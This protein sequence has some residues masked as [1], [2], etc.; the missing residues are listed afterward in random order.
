MTTKASTSAGYVVGVGADVSAPASAAPRSFPRSGGGHGD[1]DDDEEEDGGELSASERAALDSATGSSACVEGLRTVGAIVK[2][3]IGSGVLF[4][5]KAF[6]DGGWLASVVIMA[7][8]ALVTQ[9]TIVRLV[10]CRTEMLSRGARGVSFA[11]IGA[12]VGGPYAQAAVDVSLVLSQAGFCC[13]Y[14]AFIARNALQLI[15]AGACWAPG[16]HLWVLVLLQAPVLVPL[17][18]V[19]KLRSFALTNSLANAFICCGLLG[20]LTYCIVQWLR[21]SGGSLLYA[22]PAFNGPDFPV[23]LGTAVY[24]FEGIGMVVPIVVRSSFLLRLCTLSR[25]TKC[26]WTRRGACRSFGPYYFQHGV[27]ACAFSDCGGYTSARRRA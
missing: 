8:M 19:R 10:A 5:P 22:V 16:E 14:I 3:F 7:F 18:W 12:A 9:V 21:T 6:A 4:L 23:F 11:D 25:R 2:A 20:I 27:G 13:V 17:S 1:D 15:N 26:T 24:A